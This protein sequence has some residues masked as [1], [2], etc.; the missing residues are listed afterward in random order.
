MPLSEVMARWAQAQ[1]SARYKNQFG[2]QLPLEKPR[3]FREKLFVRMVLMH[4]RHCRRYTLLS[5]KLAVRSYVNQC[6][7]SKYLT[8]ITWSGA[9][10]LRAPLELYS[11]G[12]IAK[13]NHGCGGHRLITSGDQSALRRHLNQQLKQNYYWLALEA[14]YYQIK[15]KAFIEQ[16]VQGSNNLAA[17]NFRLWCFHGKVEFIQPDDGS[18]LNPFYDTSWAALNLSYRANSRAHYHCPAPENLQGMVKL[19]ET[20]A[21]PFGFVRV[22]LYN[23]NGR[24]I[25]SELTFTPLG[26]DLWL[27]PAE[28][29]SYLG[30]IWQN[31]SIA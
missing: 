4:H 15:P 24:I 1:I 20:L 19:A 17:L 11:S 8:T 25:F 6:I 3:T 27:D 13:T 2:Y 31:D 9:D 23:I 10:P 16:L 5:D 28:W 14:Q 12:Y 22:D 30:S 21:T 18:P 26:G 7:G 29:D